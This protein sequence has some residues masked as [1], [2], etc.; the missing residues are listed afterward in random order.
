MVMA[1]SMAEIVRMVFMVVW[2]VVVKR[3]TIPQALNRI[4][5]CNKLAKQNHCFLLIGGEVGQLTVRNRSTLLR[6]RTA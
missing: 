1:K 2:F 6:Y 5:V 3:I 4:C